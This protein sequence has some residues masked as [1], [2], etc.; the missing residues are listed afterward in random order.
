MLSARGND[1]SEFPD[2]SSFNKVRGHIYYVF[3]LCRVALPIGCWESIH[4]VRLSAGKDLRLKS[5]SR[6]VPIL[7]Q[8]AD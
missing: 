8:I 4:P 7:E 1:I 3:P 5:Q 2:I 6:D